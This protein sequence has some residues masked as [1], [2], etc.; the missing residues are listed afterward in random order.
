MNSDWCSKAFKY[1]SKPNSTFC[2]PGAGVVNYNCKRKLYWWSQ[3]L[4]SLK[5]ILY[6]FI[7]LFIYYDSILCIEEGSKQLVKGLVISYPICHVPDW[8]YSLSVFYPTL[9]WTFLWFKP[10]TGAD[11]ELRIFNS[12]CYEQ[13]HKNFQRYRLSQTWRDSYLCMCPHTRLF[14]HAECKILQLTL[15]KFQLWGHARIYGF[16][17]PWEVMFSSLPFHVWSTNIYE[18]I[19]VYMW[20]WILKKTFLLTDFLKHCLKLN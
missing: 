20:M 2:S 10:L 8:I 18:N 11:M 3:N 13:P 4:N 15:R 6:L 1:R 5:Y 7:Y 16:N 9:P 19:K 17:I 12:L 14:Y